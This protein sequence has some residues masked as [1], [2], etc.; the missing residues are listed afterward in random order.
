MKKNLSLFAVL[1]VLLVGTYFFQEKRVENERIEKREKDLLIKEEIT[2]LKLPHVEAHKKNGQWWSGDKLLSHNT[3]KQIEKKLQELKKVKTVEESG[4]WKSFFPNPFTIV[5]NGTT[6]TIGDMTLDKSS[7]YLAKDKEIYL[8]FIEGESTQLTTRE[9]EIESIKLNELVTLLSKSEKDLQETQL[10]RFYP[11]LP[12]ERVAIQSEGRL[13]YELDFK[14][15]ETIPP[16][17]KGV[18]AHDDLR[19]KFFSLLTQATLKQEIPYSEKLKFRKM[20]AVDF[21]D[22]G[23]TM[24]WEL[25]LIGDKKA[26]AVII[27]PDLKR[28][29]SV[30]GGTMKLYFTDIQDYWDKK[31]IPQEYFRPF[32]RIDASFIQGEKSAKVTIINK[33]PLEFESK[34][35]K[36]DQAKMDELIQY[37]FNLGPKSQ[38]DRVSNL[39]SSERKDLLSG[40][41]MRVEIMGQDLILWRKQEE[42]I[43]ANLTQGFKAHF[44]VL[45]EN[46]RATFS[47]VIK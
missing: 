8:A 24:K 12:M 4:E 37:L 25:W 38:A 30:V 31:V 6:W 19:G 1:V 23:K 34:G 16:P 27:D 9:D 15:N 10:F 32:T 28:A 36:V 44:G 45:D 41:H 3:F 18:K 42:L 39:S 14:K 26:D 43:V 29:F 17:V 13:P 20:G 35:F 11:S 5:I 40:D 2:Y 21:S 33:E 22:E 47:D 7:F 46:F